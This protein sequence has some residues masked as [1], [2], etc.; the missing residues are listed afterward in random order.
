MKTLKYSGCDGSHRGLGDWYPDLEEQITKALTAGESFTTD[1]Y[2]SKHEVASAKITAD[3]ETQKITI[4]V[5][6]SDDFDET[7]TGD[8]Y[9]PYTTDLEVIREAI[10]KAWD[11]AEQDRKDNS[12]VDMWIIEKEGS[13]VE[14]Y[15]VDK[16]PYCICNDV[17]PGDEYHKWG[18]QDEGFPIHPLTRERIEQRISSGQERFEID[19]YTV[20]LD[21]CQE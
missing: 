13:W 4:E 5:Q 20:K 7:G 17:P 1:W 14:T 19:G 16:D 6:V 12:T 3:A 10:Y 2:A 15:L 21:G 11:G 8:I 9:I 18:W